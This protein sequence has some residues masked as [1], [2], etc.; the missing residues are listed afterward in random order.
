MERLEKIFGNEREAKIAQGLLVTILEKTGPVRVIEL[1]I[2]ALPDITVLLGPE[3]PNPRNANYCS[4]FEQLLRSGFVKDI[5]EGRGLDAGT[6]IVMPEE[7]KTF[8][9]EHYMD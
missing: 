2:D 8:F 5:R 3:D 6:V 9:E 4:I 1:M 7:S